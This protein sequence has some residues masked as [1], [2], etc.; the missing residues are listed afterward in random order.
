M[1]HRD[2][3][4]ANVMV[5]TD[6]EPVILDFGTA[7]AADVSR[8]TRPGLAVGSMRFI[9]PE[10][11]RGAAPSPRTDVYALGVLAY[12]ALAGRIPYE[13]ATTAAAMLDAVKS[14]A[15][16][17][18]TVRDDVAPAV[19]DVIA[20]CMAI[21][22]NDRYAPAADVDAALAI[23]VDGA[24]VDPAPPTFAG[25][26]VIRRL[27]VGGMADVFL[28]RA[29]SAGNL[30]RVCV[31]K[32]LGSR[33]GEDRSADRRFLDEARLAIQLNHKN[34]SGVTHVGTSEAGVFLVMD[35]VAGR[36]LRQIMD[37][38][39]TTGRT[40]PVD[41]GLYI[42][43]EVLEGLDYAH[44][45]RD[46]RTGEPLRIVHR[47]VSP[48]N[49]MVSVEGEVKLI[50]FGLAASA[51]KVERTVVGTVLGKLDYISPEHA[52]GASTGPRADLYSL[53]VVGCELL[54]GGRYRADVPPERVFD[55]VREGLA[56]P[57]VD[58]LEPAP[59]DARR[60][61]PT[62]RATSRNAWW[63]GARSPG[64]ASCARSCVSCSPTRP[65]ASAS[66]WPRPLPR[67]A[68]RSSSG[69]SQASCPRRRPRSPAWIPRRRSSRGGGG[70]RPLLRR[71]GSRWRSWSVR[72]WRY[73]STTSVRHPARP[74]RRPSPCPCFPRSRAG[75]RTTRS[76]LMY[77]QR[78][79]Y[80]CSSRCRYS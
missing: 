8:V 25:F 15:P 60:A 66:S 7:T 31:I 57:L 26:R 35:Y 69:S 13:R 34:V 75:R 27:G 18:D 50:D 42:L 4:P 29:E 17:L 24:P 37:R 38:L 67:R 45:A 28:G 61:R 41:L 33:R 51:V 71:R 53:A 2:L 79:P 30:G 6:D 68:R 39:A 78:T 52:R 77:F 72:R 19:A 65:T 62:W 76:T 16:R 73:R 21:E 32:S 43:K 58:R 48:T 64:P 20:R 59:T 46:Q 12:A 70:R 63:S 49:I 10:V 23:A 44:R 54:T 3:K 9:A 5:R 14:A 1:L 56:S 80:S 11:F 36:D 40:I 55:A 74:R 47:D 22:P